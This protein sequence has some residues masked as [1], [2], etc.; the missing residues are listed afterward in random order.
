MDIPI[1]A[2]QADR[3]I[4]ETSTD[5]SELPEEMQNPQNVPP[6]PSNVD[7]PN[8]SVDPLNMDVNASSLRRS[9]LVKY[10]PDYFS[11]IF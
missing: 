2:S 9:S 7:P 3:D 5:E 1:V 4:V 8:M 10:P 11:V 6:D